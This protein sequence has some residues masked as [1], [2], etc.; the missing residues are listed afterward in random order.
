[1]G[2]YCELERKTYLLVN[3]FSVQYLLQRWPLDTN[4]KWI[5]YRVGQKK[6]NKFL[7]TILVTWQLLFGF[8]LTHPI[9]CDCALEEKVWYCFVFQNSSSERKS[10][11]SFCVYSGGTQSEWCRN[12][13]QGVSHNRLCEG[14]DD[15][16][17][18]NSCAGSDRKNVVNRDSLRDA[19]WGILQAVCII[20][21]NDMCEKSIKYCSLFFWVTGNY[22]Y[23]SNVPKLIS[24]YRL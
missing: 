18:V 4:W 10:S 20:I 22:K 7:V 5:S 15:G 12:P 8:C 13:S 6:C 19:I 16:E 17:C 21:D 24:P 23:S 1:M 14:M 9:L 3:Q 2:N 11:E